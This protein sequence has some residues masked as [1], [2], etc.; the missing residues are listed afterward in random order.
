LTVTER[1]PTL[2]RSIC[3]TAPRS[4]STIRDEYSL[5]SSGFHS[6]GFGTGIESCT[7]WRSPRWRGRRNVRRVT[8]PEG[9]RSCT[10]SV[11]ESSVAPVRRSTPSTSSFARQPVAGPLHVT[12]DIVP[13]SFRWA[14]PAGTSR[15][16]RTIPPQFHQPS[17]RRGSL[18]LSTTT[19]RRFTR[20]GR[21]PRASTANGVYGSVLRPSRRPL[22]KT[23]AARRTLSKLISQRKPRGVSGPVKLTR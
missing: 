12:R 10:S 2:R 20:P 18:R 23:V 14:R 22:R 4:R 3:C 1:S 5:G 13:S 21:R 19:T 7:R 16:G 8:R 11:G 17:G 6:S 15:T 9:D